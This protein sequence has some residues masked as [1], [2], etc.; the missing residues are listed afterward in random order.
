[1]KV[2]FYTD[3]I[4]YSRPLFT[5]LSEH[6]EMERVTTAQGLFALL[7][8]PEF[9]IAVVCVRQKTNETILDLREK[10]PELHFG[11]IVFTSTFDLRLEQF[12][13]E[14][15]ADHVMLINTPATLIETK[16]HNL[17][18]RLQQSTA[19][20]TLLPRLSPEHKFVFE[21]IEVSFDHSVIKYKGEVMRLAP[22]HHKLVAT[23][24]TRVDQLLT[25]ELLLSLIW[26]G[27]NISKRSIDAQISKL[28]KVLPPLQ[29]ALMNLYG[30]GYVLRTRGKKAA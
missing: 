27:Q 26:P 5:G 19:Y 30:R 17:A 21:D 6:L 22:T 4:E 25:R 13:F 7:E 2:A 11:L 3:N 12:C 8:M 28:K 10:F 14:H 23:F 18:R 24:V 15:G 9:R 1:M 20:E 16:V 29:E